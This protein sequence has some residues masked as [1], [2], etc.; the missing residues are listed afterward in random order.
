ME[1]DCKSFAPESRLTMSAD[2]CVMAAFT[3]VGVCVAYAGLHKSQK[4]HIQASV[5]PPVHFN[6]MIDRSSSGSRC[7]IGQYSRDGS[8]LA[9]AFQDA[10]IRVYDVLK[11]VSC[12][13]A[14]MCC[15]EWRPLGL[16]YRQW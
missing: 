4:Q 16:L 8:L 13:A 14:G 7:Y 15:D 2:L 10:H 6:A 11:C 1:L 12:S 9:A 3:S 5:F